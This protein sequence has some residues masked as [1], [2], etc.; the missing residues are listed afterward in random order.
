MKKKILI[1]AGG[2]GG[3]LLPAQQLALLLKSDSEILFAGL[4][5]SKSPFFQREG[6]DFQEISSAPLSN[7]LRFCFRGAKG[8]FQSLKLILSFKPDIVVGFGSYHSF[9][10]LAAA[11]LLKK[12]IVLYEA[13]CILGKVNRLFSPFAE[14]IAYQFP[15][16]GKNGVKFTPV[17]FFPWI[18]SPKKY[19]RDEA[20]RAYGLDSS[21][22]I[23]LVFGGSQ[24]AS[25]LNQAAPEAL[26]GCQ[27]IHFTGREETAEIVRKDYQKLGIKAAVKGFETDMAKAYAAADFALCRSGAGTTA[28]LIRHRM[29]AVLVPF[30]QAAEDHQSANARYFCEIAKGGL[31]LRQSEQ[32]R[33]Q[34]SIEE[35]KNRLGELRESL[36]SFNQNKGTGRDLA[37]LV[38]E[39]I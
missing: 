29:P 30:P 31:W 2:S 1:A 21:R 19:S 7:L 34:S 35:C 20:I 13:N 8:F 38:R 33:L 39:T 36:Q 37:D 17:P 16:P 14:K 5:L 11:A 4:Y 3:H 22:P 25:F 23:C 9:P 32:E 27:A 15:I 24:G 18:L 26:A 10:V 12:K 28:E 6:F